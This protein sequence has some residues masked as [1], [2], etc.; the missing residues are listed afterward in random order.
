MLVIAAFCVPVLESNASA[1]ITVTA[2]VAGANETGAY[3]VLP[4]G[5]K[6]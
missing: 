2:V 5:N 6:T 4:I 3:P 1:F